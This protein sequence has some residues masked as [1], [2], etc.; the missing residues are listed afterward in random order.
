MAV[1]EFPYIVALALVELGRGEEA[2]P[3]LRIAEDKMPTRRRHVAVAARALLEGR[4]S[5]SVAAMQALLSPDFRDPEGRFYV[6]RH[7]ARHGEAGEALRQLEAIVADGFFCYPVLE[8]DSWF[9]ALRDNPA[10]TTLLR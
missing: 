3:A 1:G 10:F 7:I 5:D 6:A 8:R 9:D 2:I 4:V